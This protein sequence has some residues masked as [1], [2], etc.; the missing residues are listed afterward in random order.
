MSQHKERGLEGVFRVVRIA[1][2]TTADAEH[3]RPVP[4][5]Q[6]FKRG[7]CFLVSP[8]EK[9]VQ[10]LP[11]GHLPSR[12]QGEQPLHQ[13]TRVRHVARHDLW[14]PSI[15]GCLCV[16]SRSGCFLTAILLRFAETWIALRSFPGS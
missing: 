13:T 7:L 5:H 3:H 15:S 10:E 12:A 8:G 6:L 14:F 1:Q 2:H 16:V 11:V 4:G 9:P